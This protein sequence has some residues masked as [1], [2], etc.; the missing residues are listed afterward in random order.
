MAS[1]ADVA[2]IVLSALACFIVSLLQS[3]RIPPSTTQ[4]KVLPHGGERAPC[5]NDR[6]YIGADILLT[7]AAGAA[8]YSKQQVHDLNVC[9]N[10]RL[11]TGQYLILIVGKASRVLRMG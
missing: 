5:D 8:T 2:V 1:D 9:W 6:P 4:S 3:R 10:T 11:C 7:F